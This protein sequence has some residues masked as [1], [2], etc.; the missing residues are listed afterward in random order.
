[1]NVFQALKKDINSSPL[2]QPTKK[3]RLKESTYEYF[4]LTM[5]NNHWAKIVDF[6]IKIII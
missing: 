5:F 6:L 1:M 4:I 3:T 2:W